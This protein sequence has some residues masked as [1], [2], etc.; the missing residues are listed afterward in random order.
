MKKALMVAHVAYAIDMFNLPNIAILQD[1]GYEVYVACNFDDT[2][3]LSLERIEGLKEKLSKLNVKYFNIPFQRNPLKKENIKAYSMLKEL[4]NSEGFSLIHCH[5]P[6]GG[7][8]TRLAAASER[9]KGTKVIYTAH[10]FHFFKGAPLINWLIY[11][12]AEW[13]C[14]FFTDLLI[15]INKEDYDNAKRLLH[16]KDVRYVPG[17]GVDTDRFAGTREKRQ[18]LLSL[19]HAPQD[20][21]ILLSVGELSDRK[22]HSLSIEALSKGQSKNTHLVIAGRGEKLDELT[23]LCEKLNVKDRV[24]LL[25]FRNDIAELMKSADIFVFPSLQE[26]LPVAL[27]EAMSCSLPSICSKIRGNVDL[28]DNACGILC[29]KNDVSAFSNAID[30]LASNEALRESMAKKAFEKSKEYDI[31]IIEKYMKDIYSI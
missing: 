30:R 1:L 15:T 4:I 25:G 20:S 17:V 26:G 24:H 31:K 12:T 8:L 18:E 2:S 5:T 21:V 27:M 28:I 6:V 7:I 19:I 16:A 23:Q 11:F 9:K 29:E 13:F 10:G 22:N 14:S 3:S